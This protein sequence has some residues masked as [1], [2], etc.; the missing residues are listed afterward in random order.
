MFPTAKGLF[1]DIIIRSEREE[2]LKIN[3]ILH[4]FYK[5]LN[6][7]MDIQEYWWDFV[8]SSNRR[9]RGLDPKS[10]FLSVLQMSSFVV[11]FVIFLCAPSTAY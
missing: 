10:A 2:K 11:F 6:A 7:K 4:I 8:P 1:R 9:E 5:T 3:I